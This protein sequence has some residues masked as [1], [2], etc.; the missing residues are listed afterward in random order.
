MKEEFE[1][2]HILKKS[3]IRRLANSDSWYYCRRLIWR[4]S[5]HRRDDYQ[6]KQVKIEFKQVFIFVL[7][8]VTRSQT[9]PS[10]GFG[11]SSEAGTRSYADPLAYWNEKFAQKEPK[12]EISVILSN[13]KHSSDK[14]S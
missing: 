13:G 2:K 10:V 7:R 12:T 4:E 1:G 9:D 3:F 6:G 14:S 11:L 5:N 8:A